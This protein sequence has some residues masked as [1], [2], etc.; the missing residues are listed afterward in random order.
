MRQVIAQLEHVQW[1]IRALLCAQRGAVLIAW[2][3]AALLALIAFDY[4]LRLPEAFRMVLLLAGL[5]G[6]GYAVWTYLLPA[7]AFNPSVTQLALRIERSLPSLSGRLASSIEFAMAG[8]DQTNPLAARSLRDAESRLTGDKLGRHVNPHRTMLGMGLLLMMLAI[9]G[10]FVAT[11]PA[12]AETGVKR[13]LLPFSDAAWPARTGIESRMSEVLTETG[14]FP[15]GQALPLRAAVTKG[16]NAQRIEA[17]FRT[18]VEGRFQPWQRVVLT[19]QGAGPIHER[20]VDSTAEAIEVYFTSWDDRTS[21]EQITLVAPPAVRQARAIITPPSYAADHV[22]TYEASLGPGVD[23][24]SV[25]D[26]PSLIG[27]HV[28]MTIELNKPLPVPQGGYAFDTWVRATLGWPGEDA[29]SDIEGPGVPIPGLWV[30]PDNEQLWT[31]RWQLEQTTRL[32]LDLVDEHGLRNVEPINYRIEAVADHPPS[33][34]IVEPQSDEAV[35]K[36][37]QIDLIAEAQD[38]VAL[39]NVA[40]SGRVQ[41][42]GQREPDENVVWS[43]EDTADA[44][45][46]RLHDRLDLATLNVDDGDVVHVVATATDNYVLDDQTHDPVTSSVRRLRIISEIE[47]ASQLRR[48]LS[49][50]RQNAIRL[51]AMQS[52]L[53]DSIIDDSVRPG[54]ERAQAQIAERIAQQQQS[55][56]DI[57]RQMREN[58]LDDDQLESLLSQSRDL[59]DF[60]GRAASRATEEIAQRRAEGPAE[61]EDEQADAQRRE[62]RDPHEQDRAIVESQQEVRE[63]LSD[64]IELLDRDEDTWVVTR[65]MQRVLEQQ[66]Q[67]QQDT[68]RIGQQTVGLSLDELSQEM[69]S[70]LDRIAMRQQDLRD[71]ARELLENLRQRAESMEEIDP[72]AA[73][74]MRSAARTGEQRELDRQME[75]A[76]QRVQQNQMRSAGQSQQAASETLQRMLQDIEETNRARAEQLLRQLASLLES[77][78]RLITVQENELIALERALDADDFTGRD[79]AMIRLNQNTQAVATE[80][81]QAGQDTRRIA[82]TLDRAADAQSAAVSALRAQP[83]R[84]DDAVDAENRSLELLKEAKELAEELQQQTQEDELRRQREELIDTYREFAELQMTV[85]E[86]TIELMPEP[87]TEIGRRELVEARRLGTRQEDIRTGM[88]ELRDRT[89]ELM[90]S[91]VF[92]HVHGRVDEWSSQVRSD[93]NDGRVDINVTDRQQMIVRSIGRLIEA[94]EESMRPPDDFDSEQADG[95]GGGGGDQP[96]I[97]PITELRLLRGIQQEVYE[98]TKDLDLRGDLDDPQRRQ[99]LRDLGREQR[100]LQ[101]LGEEMLERLRQQ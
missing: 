51:E 14:V 45:S 6:L 48:Q 62:M 47:F 94:L 85:R 74:G 7:V 17:H 53:Q 87:G 37:A 76:G 24:R 69:L 12:A 2:I 38:D 90:D 82:R 58:R 32:S 34:T 29:E 98:S 26:T 64:L 68:A 80:A 20:L 23:H 41:K 19:Q 16:D 27:S 65:Q 75:E 3:V 89:A 46:V 71:E 40:M 28:E 10:S 4:A 21:V 66:R 52:E 84:F 43:I 101:R 100:D 42:S 73:S 88:N 67:L 78:E 18:S 1:R 44:P 31:L 83:L 63:E 70:E 39:A 33:V 36:T 77:I 11:N 72:Q 95:G 25:T 60:A 92:T 57:Q 49:A 79:R 56:N 54:A 15:R 30:N 9:A 50:V 99:R 22:L 91:I 81:R 13:I 97:P 55:I 61:I 59:L 35:L 8:V 93:L 86:S 96:L 5:A